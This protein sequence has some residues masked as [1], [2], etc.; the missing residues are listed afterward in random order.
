MFGSHI[1]PLYLTVSLVRLTTT[2]GQPATKPTSYMAHCAPCRN[3]TVITC[4]HN[5]MRLPCYWRWFAYHGD[6]MWTTNWELHMARKEEGMEKWQPRRPPDIQANPLASWAMATTSIH[7]SIPS[8]TSCNVTNL[9]LN[10][11]LH[12]ALSMYDHT[13]YIFTPHNIHIQA[14]VAKMVVRCLT[15]EE[16]CVT[17]HKPC[18]PHNRV[19]WHQTGMYIRVTAQ[20][21]SE[22]TCNI[23]LPGSLH[24]CFWT[25]TGDLHVSDMGCAMWTDSWSH[26][27]S[28]AV[29]LLRNR[30]G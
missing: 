13:F 29:A 20:H 21:H 3:T 9:S 23:N 12:C 26:I 6:A 11:Q 14:M 22:K 17:T 19:Q 8:W 18:S 7:Q 28:S 1:L 5:N 16:A 25:L 30:R 2:Q 10:T 15:T 4:Q 27:L 24:L